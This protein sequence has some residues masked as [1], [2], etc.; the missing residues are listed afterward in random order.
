MSV[1]Y[2][3]ELADEGRHTPITRQRSPWVAQAG[4][5]SPVLGVD[6]SWYSRN[7]S[8]G[9]LWACVADEPGIGWHVSISY[10]N[11]RGEPTRYPTWDE[12]VHAL[13]EIGPRVPFAMYLPCDD[14][15]YVALHPSTFHWHQ[16]HSA[17]DAA[18]IERLRRECAHLRSAC[19][20][21]MNGVADAVEPLGYDREAACGPAD[22]LPGLATLVER[23]KSHAPD[24][25][26]VTPR[27]AAEDLGLD[28]TVWVRSTGRGTHDVMAASSPVPV[29][30]ASVMFTEGV[31]GR[32]LAL[33]RFAAALGSVSQDV[34]K[35]WLSLPKARRRRGSA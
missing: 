14:A 19:S 32:T 33:E 31:K 5:P 34:V 22:L 26:P 15:G 20:V 6:A 10:R 8:D 18:E 28:D 17:T 23:S 25:E 16:D 11:H 9:T 29:V 13:R 35:R 4:L 2:R 21:W 30:L 7:V 12:Q 1:R 3:Q 27:E 24:P